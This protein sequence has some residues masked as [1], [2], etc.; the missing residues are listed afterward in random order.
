[1]GGLTPVRRLACL[2]E[3]YGVKTAWHGSLDMTPIALAVQAHLGYA[4]PNFG[5]QEYYGY[6]EA[7]AE[8]F[9]GMPAV[10]NGS[11]VL[12]DTPGHGVS[13]DERRAAAYP[14]HEGPT[15][16]TEMRLP[17]GTLHTP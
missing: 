12:S 8:I 16:W 5:I 15:H 6:G 9:P 1:M 14:P 2:A 7:T 17:D 11:L 3:H 13:F 4:S 10:E